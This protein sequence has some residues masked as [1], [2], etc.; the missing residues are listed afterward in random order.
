[1]TCILLS[2]ATGFVG[3]ATARRLLE[4]DRVDRL[5]LLA[6]SSDNL[7]GRDRLL[8]S[9]SRFGPVPERWR[10]VEV[11]T[12]DLT[13]VAL[14]RAVVDAVTHV[15]HAA[16]CTSLRSVK[17]VRE[18]NVAGTAA[19]ADQLEEAPRLR[20]FLFVSTAYRCGITDA[21]VVNEDTPA[22]PEHVA[23]YT[24]SKSRAEE[25]LLSRRSF[26]LLIARPSVVV[27]HSR[28]GVKPSASMF[29]YYRALAE[30]GVSPFAPD[31]RRD[32]V[33]V[34]HVADALV[35]LTFSPS[36]RHRCYHVSAGARSSVRWGDIEAGFASSGLASTRRQSV[37]PSTLATHPALEAIAAS[38][39]N[40]RAGVEA[41][42][43][44]SGLPIEWFANER[45]VAEG[46]PPPPPF[47]DYLRRCIESSSRSVLEQMRDDA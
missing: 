21:R 10:R 18:S 36:P 14:D 43:R 9:I 39:R 33:P 20:R 24:R 34:D 31:K 19:I 32:I 22:A 4:D 23:E 6:R 11:I 37:D 29:W 27:G 41:C 28:L 35:F 2:G 15:I 3:G 38:D 40:F 44:F 30:A 25:D 5:V 45:L 8:Q 26:P 7:K 12:G 13:T 47:T 17:R 1:M 16:A 46:M 42:A